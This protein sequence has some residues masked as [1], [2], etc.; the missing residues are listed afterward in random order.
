[1]ILG[2][3]TEGSVS[4]VPSKLTMWLKRLGRMLVDLTKARG[5]GFEYLPGL[6]FLDGMMQLKKMQIAVQ[7]HDPRTIYS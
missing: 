6:F 2:S 7:L 1:M 4:D 5:H 3:G